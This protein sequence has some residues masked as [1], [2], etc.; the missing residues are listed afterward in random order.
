MWQCSVILISSAPPWAMPADNKSK[1]CIY[2]SCCISA[3]LSHSSTKAATKV[4]KPP[5]VETSLA[6]ITTEATASDW[7][8]YR[9]FNT[10]VIICHRKP[11][12]F[13]SLKL[14]L[15]AVHQAVFTH[16]VFIQ[17]PQ[18]ERGETD[19]SCFHLYEV[20]LWGRLKYGLF[21]QSIWQPWKTICLSTSN[22]RLSF[23][24][25]AAVS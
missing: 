25:A 9:W 22:N 6:P 21:T 19:T 23:S 15:S 7:E 4:P 2:T 16:V 12:W 3:N 24:A 5:G 17:P 1:A 8:K 13:S 20:T 10:N 11:I 18:R 14:A